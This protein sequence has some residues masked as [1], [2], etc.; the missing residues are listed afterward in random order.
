MKFSEIMEKSKSSRKEKEQSGSMRKW[1]FR[2]VSMMVLSMSTLLVFA[3]VNQL[4]TDKGMIS[5]IAPYNS[6]VRQAILQASQY[7]EILTQLQKSQ[8]QTRA[9]FQDIIGDFRREKQNWFYTLTRYPE[10]MH[11][12]ATLPKRE[13]KDAIYQLL[14]NQSPELREAAW[15]LYRHEKNDLVEMDNIKSVAQQEF[16][17]TI[18]NLDELTANA[19]RKLSALP[20]VLTLMTNNI[21]L[22]SKLGNQYR[23]NP[24]QLDN[25]LAALHDSLNVQSQYEIAALKK[26]LANDPQAVQELGQA[27][28]DYA[29]A[30]GY[31]LPNQQNYTSN[32]PN[33]YGSNYYGNPYSYWFGYPFWYSSPMWYP[34]GFGFYSGFYTGLGGFG[35][36]GF[37]SYGFS[38]WFFNS[39]YYNRYPNLYRQ[40]GNYYRGH[41]ADNRVLGS[42]NNGFMG[43]AGRHFNTNNGG[44]MGNFNS[45]S[46]FSRAG[47]QSYQNSGNSFRA[48]AGSYR[49]QSSGFSGV[50]GFSGGGGGGFHGGGGSRG[51]GGRH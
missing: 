10:L 31:N 18:Q 25:Q 3:Q 40:F 22:I 35:M 34:G 44:R 51:G 21:D 27:T 9:T 23:D 36:Y 7:P 19:F 37:P 8:S 5:S 15:Q 24:I 42:V 43:V 4:E 49:T 20:D 29:A 45:S 39:G 38:N 28:K 1:V 48:N 12:L 11:T 32:Y 33:Y 2:G 6:D 30:N 47:R 50:R 26:Q 16:D 17:K 14:P 13:D 46:G 41:S